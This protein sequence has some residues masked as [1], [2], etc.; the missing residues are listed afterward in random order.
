MF[1]IGLNGRKSGLDGD[2]GTSVN[3]GSIGTTSG[4]RVSEGP[5]E[6][7]YTPNSANLIADL[8]TP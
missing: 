3:D 5:A 8:S 4:H 7:C 2:R 1:T 6:A